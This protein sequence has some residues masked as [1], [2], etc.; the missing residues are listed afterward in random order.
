M[1]QMSEFIFIHFRFKVRFKT[2]NFCSSATE[3][4]KR[5]QALQIKC[6][7]LI[8]AKTN[9]V[10]AVS[11]DEYFR[12]CQKVLEDQIGIQSGGKDRLFQFCMYVDTSHMLVLVMHR[13]VFIRSSIGFSPCKILNS[14][15]MLTERIL[16]VSRTRTKCVLN[17]YRTHTECIPNAYRMHTERIPNAYRTH[18]ECVPNMYRTEHV[19]STYRTRTVHVLNSFHLDG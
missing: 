11:S 16:N 3:E 17:A 8:G 12:M 1:L 13:S 14:Y 10:V 2:Q 6:N 9:S 15:Q 4:R 5:D 19:S 7:S 18:T